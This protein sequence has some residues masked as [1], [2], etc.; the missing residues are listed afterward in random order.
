MAFSCNTTKWQGG[1]QTPQ[2]CPKNPY[3]IYELEDIRAGLRDSIDPM[4]QASLGLCGTPQY[5]DGVTNTST[6][7]KYYCGIVVLRDTILNVAAGQSNEVDGSGVDVSL[8]PLNG[9]TLPAGSIL[10]GNWKKVVL[11]S[12]NVKLMPHP[13]L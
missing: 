4:T 1:N 9:V 5:L 10:L 11:V 12:G 2:V 7:G 6:A 3:R 8:T 13:F